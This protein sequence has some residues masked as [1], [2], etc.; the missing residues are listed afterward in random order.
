[1]EGEDQAVRLVLVVILREMQEE[2]PLDALGGGQVYLVALSGGTLLELRVECLAT[3]LAGTSM[4]L[5]EEYTKSKDA[6]SPKSNRVCHI[7][8]L[9]NLRTMV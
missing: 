9:I 7:F 1:M 8:S 5:A 4:S 6:E 3:A 2:R